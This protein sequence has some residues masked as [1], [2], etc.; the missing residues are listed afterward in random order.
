MAKYGNEHTSHPDGS[1]FASRREARRYAE[2]KMLADSGFITKLRTQVSYELI[3]KQEG[4]RAC[5]Y[6]ADFTYVDNEGKFHCEDT[7]GFRTDVY[8]VKRK[9]M[10]W[11]HKIRIEE[12]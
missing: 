3:P 7:K 12:I 8:V 1:V 9:L 2:L 6:L 5:V 10:L 11:V 4:E